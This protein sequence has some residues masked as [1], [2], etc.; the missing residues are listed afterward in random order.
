MPGL[1]AIGR[2][3]HRVRDAALALLPREL[4]DAG[5]HHA[6]G[7][8]V[9]Q[10]VGIVLLRVQDGKQQG[11]GPVG[12]R[13]VRQ[14]LGS[15]IEGL[16]AKAVEVHP[17]GINRVVERARRV[18]V[19]GDPLLVRLLAE[20]R[21]GREHDVRQPVMSRDPLPR[22]SRTVRPDRDADSLVADAGVGLLAGV[23]LLASVLG[24]V[25]EFVREDQLI[26]VAEAVEGS[27]GVSVVGPALV[28]RYVPLHR[29]CFSAV[30]GLVEAQ[31]VVIALRT[32]EPLGRANHVPRIGRVNLDVGFRVVV[33]QH[34][35]RCREP[36][37][38]SLLS[39]IRPLILTRG[40]RAVARRLTRVPV[41]GTVAHG[42]G[43]FRRVATHLL[44]GGKDVRDMVRRKTVCER[45]FSLCSLG[46]IAYS[47]PEG[48]GARRG[49]VADCEDDR[50][51]KQKQAADQRELKGLILFLTHP[52][53]ISRRLPCAQFTHGLLLP[54]NRGFWFQGLRGR[55]ILRLAGL[56]VNGATSMALASDAT[57]AR[58][59]SRFGEQG[60]I[61]LESVS[62]YYTFLAMV[63]NVARTALP[64]GSAPA[65]AGFPH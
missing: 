4:V 27:D 34:G 36:S 29:P 6:R 12:V 31:H 10:Q 23:E 38:A 7:R 18:V 60:I 3:I 46:D 20:A 25:I 28:T 1:P 57:Y 8:D 44:R 35:G 26:V 5:P 2:E 52:V 39:G 59:L 15:R 22:A 61:D 47:R 21:I 55:R 63:L 9:W 43:N 62:G 32:G 48:G 58:A 42:E 65:L 56:V 41:D 33:D 37:V 49:S 17:H 53:S 30:P 19:Y 16:A 50:D 14:G 51:A 40:G 45:V 54:S 64:K 24:L 13:A 11:R